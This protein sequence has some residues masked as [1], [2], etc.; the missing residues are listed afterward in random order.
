MKMQ[1]KGFMCALCLLGVFSLVAG[2]SVVTPS[3]LRETCRRTYT[4]EVPGDFVDIHGRIVTAMNTIGWG[5]A[6][7][8]RQ[9]V[10]AGLGRASTWASYPDKRNPIG[11]V[12]DTERLG[13]NRTRIKVYP[14][15]GYYARKSRAMIEAALQ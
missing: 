11:F 13:E 15:S 10:H 5:E 6:A 9:E 4:M 14:M 1:R 3:R 7:M 12:I 2:C 8:V